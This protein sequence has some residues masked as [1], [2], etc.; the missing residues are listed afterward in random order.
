M[1]PRDKQGV[2]TLKQV[3]QLELTLPGEVRSEYLGSRVYVRFNHGFE[4]AGLQMVRALRRL[5]LRQFNV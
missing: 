4:P 5:L 2:S 1:D 3:F